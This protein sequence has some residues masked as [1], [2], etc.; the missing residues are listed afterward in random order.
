MVFEVIEAAVLLR[1]AAVLVESGNVVEAAPDRVVL[2]VVVVIRI[3]VVV[4]VI[5]VELV[6]LV[7]VVDVVSVLVEV[8]W[9]TH[10]R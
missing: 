5:S 6:V 3:V 9:Q 7:R 1:L 4:R 8:D 2:I 10:L